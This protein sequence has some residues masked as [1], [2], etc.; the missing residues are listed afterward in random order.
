[1]SGI[2][3]MS[4]VSDEPSGFASPSFKPFN[5]SPMRLDSSVCLVI[6]FKSALSVSP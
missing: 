2:L 1:V 3:F 6:I 5:I 4:M